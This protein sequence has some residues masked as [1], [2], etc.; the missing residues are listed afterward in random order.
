MR[1]AFSL[2]LVALVANLASAPVHAAEPLRVDLG[3]PVTPT[4]GSESAPIEVTVFS[5][6]QCPFCSR[7]EPVL[8]QLAERYGER[9]SVSFRHFPLT[10][11]H[12]DAFQAAEASLCAA[13]QGRFPAMHEALFTNAGALD[14]DALDGYAAEIGLDTAAFGA[15]LDAGTH[16]EKVEADLEAGRKAGVAG[17]P[18][19]FV[20]GRPITLRRGVDPLDS[21]SRVVDQELNREPSAAVK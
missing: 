15:C 1:T 18:T 5:D 13:D 2:V 20:N 21:L 9:L 16:R 6:Y 7:M 11:I 14:R 17:T 8:D 12:P 3:E 4:R 19:L 10:R